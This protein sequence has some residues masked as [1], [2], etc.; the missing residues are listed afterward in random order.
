MSNENLNVDSLVSVINALQ[1]TIGR[2]HAT[3]G[4]NETRTRNMLIDPLI[5]ALG[6]ADSSVVT[7][8]YLVRFGARAAD[9]GVVDY[10]LHP[11]DQR[12]H[13]IAFIEAKRMNEDLTD[14]HRNQ[15]LT[16][17]FD[18]GDSIQYVGLTNGNDWE[19]YEILNDE[20]RIVFNLSIR[21]QS[22]IDCA[23]MFLGGFPMLPTTQRRRR[24]GPSAPLK[25]AVHSAATLPVAPEISIG[26]ARTVNILG[27]LGWFAV[28]LVLGGIVGYIVGFR[29][30]Q[31]IGGAFAPFG[32]IVAAIAVITGA[33]LAR[34]FLRISLRWIL[35]IL[36]FARLFGSMSGDSRKTLMWVGVAFVCGSAIGGGPGYLIGMRTAQLILDM[37]AGL[38]I[39]VFG[40]LIAVAVALLAIA[41]ARPSRY[42]YGRRRNSYSFGRRRRRTR[43]Y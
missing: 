9:Y 2:D 5:R 41:A 37:F 6:W 38:G 12:G 36:S 23:N 13:P 26:Q 32:I 22:A 40:A 18:K 8:E 28:F 42:R 3:I 14:D 4:A 21:E 11:P 35:D 1:N 10:A 16:Y 31:P 24:S 34:S 17:A 20:Y 19:V 30:A 39:V 33:I 25:P 27:I 7:Q 43:R 15:A 29:S